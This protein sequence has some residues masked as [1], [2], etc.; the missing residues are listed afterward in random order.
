MRYFSGA[1]LAIILAVVADG[2]IAQGLKIGY[3]DPSRIQN[4]SVTARQALEDMKKEFASRED[5]LAKLQKRATDLK[6]ELDKTPDTMQP[7][8]RQAKEN[9]FTNMARE[10][11]QMQQNLAE[12]IELRKRE[13]FGRVGSEAN[14]VI[15]QIAASGN[16]DLI[17]QDVAFSGQRTDITD[18]V[19]SEMAKRLGANG[20][21]GK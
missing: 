20:N 14:A 9:T 4:E 15:Q 10:V 6:N 17:V 18:Q 13:E 5:A 11:Q 3:V 19:L 16:Y 8:E 7:D 12:D 21:P 2:A 1:C